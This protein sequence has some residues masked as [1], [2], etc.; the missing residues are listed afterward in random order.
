MK[1]PRWLSRAF[2]CLTD[3]GCIV[4]YAEKRKKRLRKLTLSEG[5]D[6]LSTLALEGSLETLPDLE[7][8]KSL[9]NNGSLKIASLFRMTRFPFDI[10]IS[11]KHKQPEKPR[12]PVFNLRNDLQV[13]LVSRLLKSTNNFMANQ[14]GL[15]TDL[16]PR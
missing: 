8:N 12:H 15:N 2:L 7:T 11:Q 1:C 6:L 13:P 14:Q 16:F 5:T 3:A 4:E 10:V 9:I